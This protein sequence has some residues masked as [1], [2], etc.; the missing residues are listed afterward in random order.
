MTFVIA[1]ASCALVANKLGKDMLSQHREKPNY[2]R[3]HFLRFDVEH[4]GSNSDIRDCLKQEN[5]SG[6]DPLENMDHWKNYKGWKDHDLSKDDDDGLKLLAWTLFHFSACLVPKERMPG[7]DHWAMTLIHKH[8]TCDDIAFLL[9]TFEN[10][11]NRWTHLH[12][13][14]QEKRKTAI[15]R[16]EDPAK[17]RLVNPQDYK[18]VPATQFPVGSG[19]SGREGQERFNHLKVYINKKLFAHKEEDCQRIW[20][21]LQKEFKRLAKTECNRLQ[22]KPESPQAAKPVQVPA[23]QHEHVMNP[24]LKLLQDAEWKDLM[25]PSQE[26]GDCLVEM[27]VGST[28]AQM[29]NSRNNC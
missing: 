16:G 17:V 25:N 7:T 19:I 14:L 3:S 26:D 5:A 24:E 15:E 1:A 8:L 2:I 29:E 27:A 11:I 21:A 6:W 9:L 23:V 10:N 22:D 13:K 18:G 4:R 20:E 28:A 12:Q